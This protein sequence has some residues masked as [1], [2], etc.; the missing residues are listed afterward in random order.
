MS[1]INTAIRRPADV[2]RQIKEKQERKKTLTHS[3]GRIVQSAMCP[4]ADDGQMVGSG[5]Q[6]HSEDRVFVG[7]QGQ[8]S[9][10][11]VMYE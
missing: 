8:H 4:G 10:G 2:K 7:R 5:G 9:S 1:S 11:T 6:S 3:E